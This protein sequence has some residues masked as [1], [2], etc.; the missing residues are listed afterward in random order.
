M[1]Q[2]KEDLPI[3]VDVDLKNGGTI[4]YATEVIST[5]AGVAA[6]E[7]EGIAGMCISGGLSDIIGRNRNITRGVKVE[8]GG[9]EAS[10]D[11]YVI[12]EYGQPIQKVCHDV[13][14][15]VRK[16]IESMTGLHVLRVDVHVQGVSFEKEKKAQEIGIE[17]SRS[18]ALVA[19]AAIEKAKEPKKVQKKPVKPAEV[20]AAEAAPTDAPKEAE[21][22]PEEAAPAAAEDAL[23]APAL[24]EQPAEKPSADAEAMPQEAD[25]KKPKARKKKKAAEKDDKL[26]ETV[27]ELEPLK[28]VDDEHDAKEASNAAGNLE[29]A[30]TESLAPDAAPAEEEAQEDEAEESAIDWK[31]GPAAGGSREAAVKTDK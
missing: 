27:K 5:I 21:K 17:A 3:N 23:E 29:N 25:E 16:A 2:K 26:R 15:N 7:I 20:P 18:P 9:E 6:N 14:E 22:A 30:I 28:V 12:V 11:L 8:M 13:Q 1:A 10:F 24:K 4:T 31:A 19:P